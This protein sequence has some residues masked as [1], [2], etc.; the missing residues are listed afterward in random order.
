V[1][2]AADVQA[3][4]R[5]ADAQAAPDLTI[6]SW[7]IL[8]QRWADKCFADGEYPLAT[9][10]DILWSNRCPRIVAELLAS[11][12]DVILLQEVDAAAFNELLPK[13]TGYD[14]LH[15]KGNTHPCNATFWKPRLSLV[16]AQHRS[17][18]L[19]TVLHDGQAKASV[20]IVNCHLEGCPSA[21]LKRVQQLQSALEGVRH[22]GSLQAPHA[23]L[24]LAG[25]FNSTAEGAVAAYLS[26]GSVPQGTREAWG[27]AGSTA[28]PDEACAV[29]AH[30]YQLQ[31]VYGL[32]DPRAFSFA[33]SGRSGWHGLLD[34]V[35]YDGRHLRCV[36]RRQLVASEAHL[37]ALLTMG[38]PS[39]ASPSDHL[40]CGATLRWSG[41]A[42]TAACAPA[43]AAPT[44]SSPTPEQLLAEA[45][46]LLANALPS[47]ALRAEWVSV[48]TPPP[49]C[50]GK[51]PAEALAAIAAQR[52]RKED[53]LAQASPEARA[54][55]LRVQSLQKE[56]RKAASR[57]TAEQQ[58]A[59]Q[60]ATQA[61]VQKKAAA[62]AA[63]IAGW[64]FA[65]LDIAELASAAQ[66]AVDDHWLWH[67]A[68]RQSGKTPLE[69]M[70]SSATKA[71]G[72]HVTVLLRVHEC[73]A[74]LRAAC[75][76]APQPATLTVSDVFVERVERITDEEVWC[77]GLAF[78]SPAIRALRDAWLA[79]LPREEWPTH[80]PYAGE[81]HASLAYVRGEYRDAAERRLAPIRARLVGA[82]ITLPHVVFQDPRH[83]LCEQIPLG[84]QAR[85]GSVRQDYRFVAIL[86][87]EKTCER[88]AVLSPQE[89]IEVPT[90]LLDLS[91]EAPRL[92][93]EFHEHVR[94]TRHPQLSAFCTELTG[95]TQAQID[96]AAPLSTVMDRHVAWLERHGALADGRNVL[97]VTCGD[98]DLK[99]SLA[100]DP[101]VDH[102]ALPA[103]YGRWC[104][105]KRAFAAHRGQ[106]RQPAGMAEMLDALG[107]PLEGQHLSG[108]DDCRNLARVVRSLL[109]QGWKVAPTGQRAASA[110]GV[111]CMSESG[112]SSV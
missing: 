13:L 26:F 34:H 41:D 91:S 39:A 102:D 14:G 73:G 63:D 108:I 64:C 36:S 90:L 58:R 22:A 6:L 95:I 60:Q 66:E 75:A 46:E 96:A 17:R 25:D 111:T 105:L 65:P 68:G 7:N 48:T 89:I 10:H 67:R 80:C 12:A 49:P 106:K 28:V 21:S 40:P 99:R 33:P 47:E 62:K 43:C 30:A 9:A 32:D 83:G 15:Q 52:A 8:A 85:S 31:S 72:L 4:P 103:C 2:R 37:D 88:D 76:A 93:S 56:A 35:W 77:V 1:L 92:V 104:N 70:P 69:P 51:P 11:T 54:M 81:G 107:L 109:A 23:S 3:A 29:A 44:D 97:F 5:A 24:V 94:P 71:A 42:A 78:A 38:M 45:A 112:C 53:L 19:S 82:A 20:A 100:E 59:K 98:Y 55:L 57:P 50:K 27:L 61:K 86:D 74:R 18:T 101:N 79:P 87:F 16:W 84:R 110:G